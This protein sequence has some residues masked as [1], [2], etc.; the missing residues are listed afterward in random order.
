VIWGSEGT[1]KLQKLR[2]C[3]TT[4]VEFIVANATLAKARVS[5]LFSGATMKDVVLSPFVVATI[6]VLGARSRRGFF[7]GLGILTSSS[8]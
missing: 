8:R 7:M 2:V 4:R 6:G 3:Y 1:S 5:S